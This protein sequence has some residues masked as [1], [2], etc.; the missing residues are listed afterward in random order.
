MS[1]LDLSKTQM[2]DFQYNYIRKK[3]NHKEK[4]TRHRHKKYNLCN[5]N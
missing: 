2:N 4:F 1:I 5:R 3:Y